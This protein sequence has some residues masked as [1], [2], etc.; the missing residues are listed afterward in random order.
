MNFFRL[1]T[2]LCF[3]VLCAFASTS[4][5]AKEAINNKTIELQLKQQQNTIELIS[6]VLSESSIDEVRLLEFR[7]TLKLSR[8]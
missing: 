8:T 1:L 7:H 5:V 6:P 2:Y 4:V 3:F